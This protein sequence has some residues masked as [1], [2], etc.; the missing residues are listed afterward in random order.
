MTT[1]TEP[2]MPAAH[3]NSSRLEDKQA[4]RSGSATLTVDGDE[5]A[6]LIAALGYFG[7]EPHCK[8]T[9]NK[10]IMARTHALRRRLI[11]RTEMKGKP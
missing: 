6:I 1:L 10:T 8:R 9:K 7:R 11:E 4:D 5:F 3:A 2:E